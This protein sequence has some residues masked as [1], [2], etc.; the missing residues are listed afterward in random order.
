M[1]LGLG[2]WKPE[3]NS[4][5]NKLKEHPLMFTTG[6]SLYFE[7]DCQEFMKWEI[8]HWKDKSLQGLDALSKQYVHEACFVI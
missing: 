8:V 5:L 4:S 7:S 6:R 3:D 1:G 2:T